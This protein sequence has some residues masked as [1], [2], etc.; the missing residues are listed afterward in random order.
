MNELANSI[1]VEP[2]GTS[3]VCTECDKLVPKELSER[4]H[5]C[6]YCGIE[7]DRDHN[8]AREIEHRGL[9]KHNL[10]PILSWNKGAV[11]ALRE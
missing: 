6:P 8:S 1:K 2:R 5:K 7:L 11:C 10:L 4:M 3:Q 9:F